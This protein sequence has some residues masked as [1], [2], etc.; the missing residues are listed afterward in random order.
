[1]NIELAPRPR[2]EDRRLVA[3]KRTGVIDGNQ[4]GNFSVF[5]DIAKELTD[6][7]YVAFSLFDE[8]FQCKISTTNNTDN[9]KSLRDEFNVCSYVL[10]SAEPTLIHDL[11]KHDRWMNHPK[12]KSGEAEYL[13]YAGFPVINKDNYAL[14]SF[15]LLNA[16][17]KSLT[18]RQIELI[19]GLTDRIAHQLDIQTEQKEA[20]SET[21]RQVV[22]IF[23]T[24]AK[25]DSLNSLRAFLTI[26]SGNN[27]SDK[28]Y[29]VLQNLNLVSRN[30]KQGVYITNPGIQLQ[31]KMKL[32][33]RVM[34]RN[35]LT[36]DSTST[37][38]DELLGDL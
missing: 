23:A 37:F 34:K 28:D 36:S 31:Q 17:A 22:K 11:S 30:D 38:L 25:S 10:L 7:D 6:F 24:V 12:I 19:N 27:I 18:G 1:M 26:C 32:Q 35:I 20:T 13:G 14:G 2:N 5:C 15:C 16:E 33:T 8:N 21:C 9:V 4:N 29:D 3:V